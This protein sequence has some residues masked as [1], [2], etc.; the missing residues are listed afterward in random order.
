MHLQARA[1]EQGLP[2]FRSANTGISALI[3]PY[4]RIIHRLDLNTEGYIDAQ[5]LKKIGLTLYS[6]WG[7]KKWNT[8]LCCLIVLS[9]TLC[10]IR[11]NWISKKY[12]Y[13]IF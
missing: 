2:V 6:N 11:D 12:R 5:L 10:F 8:L 1:I 9:I 3:D 4:G 7:A 13:K